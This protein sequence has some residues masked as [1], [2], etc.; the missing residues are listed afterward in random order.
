MVAALMFIMSMVT[1]VALILIA[2]GLIWYMGRG[3]WDKY[4]RPKE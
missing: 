2:V 4:R 3:L 1:R